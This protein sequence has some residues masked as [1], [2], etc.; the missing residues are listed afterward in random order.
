ME[1]LCSSWLLLTGSLSLKKRK[2]PTAVRFINNHLFFGKLSAFNL[3]FFE[4]ILIGTQFERLA[5]DFSILSNILP[6]RNVQS[7][8]FQHFFKHMGMQSD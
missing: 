8:F 4:D 2:P 5:N 3:L 7:L 1:V 6:N